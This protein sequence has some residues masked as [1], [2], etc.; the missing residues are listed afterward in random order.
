MLL[1]LSYYCLA[2]LHHARAVHKGLHP[3]QDEGADGDPDRGTDF[4]FR[5][6]IRTLNQGR[7][8]GSFPGSSYR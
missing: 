1:N 5:A 4:F 2:Q 3:E 7:N 8:D 6:E